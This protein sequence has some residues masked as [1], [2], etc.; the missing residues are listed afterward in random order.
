M[1]KPILLIVVLLISFFSIAHTQN[2]TES[3]TF[4]YH[5]NLLNG[6]IDLPE[7]KEPSALIIIIPGDGPTYFA[8]SWGYNIIRK[9]LITQGI[10]LCMWDKQGCGKS[11]GV[12]D[13]Q[14]T[15]QSSADEALMA[16]KKIKELKIPG[17]QRIGLWSISRG[18]WIAPLV[19]D[20][21]P[22]ITFWISVSGV[23][24]K[25]NNT[26][27]Y[28]KN[29]AIQGK[30]ADSVKILADEYRAGNRIFWEGGSFKDYLEATKNLSKDPYY[31]KI[32][33]EQSTSEEEYLKE[34]KTA[35]DMYE[36][37]DSTASIILVP[38]FSKILKNIQCP[39][40]AI[41]GE[42]D[43]QVDWQK[44]MSYYKQTIGT[45]PKSKLTIKTFPNCNHMIQK[46]KTGGMDEKD[47]GGFG[48]GFFETMNEWIKEQVFGK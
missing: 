15:V 45:N 1:K 23:D 26:Y 48:A 28:E 12:Y 14:Q 10:T 16:I 44:T 21:L 42:K 34:Q 41:F 6:F 5:D 37:D 7:K 8:D 19:I 33:G 18:G 3:F 25:D 38:G 32:H 40:L 17:S 27:L 36:F 22:S 47:S 31:I 20:Q 35:M 30:P 29:L 11:E 24:D 9:E 46:S 39:V 2:R 43:S 13:Q 4:K